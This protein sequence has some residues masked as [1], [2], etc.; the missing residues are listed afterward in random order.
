MSKILEE[1]YELVDRG[2]MTSAE[3]R[4]FLFTIPTRFWTSTNP[5]FFA[6]T[7]VDGE[8]RRFLAG[9]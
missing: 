5:N 6:G 9:T 3:L 2:L 7:A 1:A 4:D 8:V